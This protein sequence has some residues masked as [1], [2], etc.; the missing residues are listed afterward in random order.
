MENLGLILRLNNIEQD[1]KNSIKITAIILLILSIFG[2][3]DE[4]LPECVQGKVI[5]YQSCYNVNV[6]QVLS[7][8]LK[9]E[10]IRWEG[11]QYQ[12]VIQ[13]PGGALSE[14]IIYFSYR[15]FNAEQD[16]TYAN[17][18]CPAN[19]APLAV[20]MIVITDYSTEYCP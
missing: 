4:S 19:L 8:T 20:P 15:F 11:E 1:M 3:E 14:E 18:I 7:G 16:S 6:I 12:N 5:G 2:C 17:L 9:G 10:E 13:Y